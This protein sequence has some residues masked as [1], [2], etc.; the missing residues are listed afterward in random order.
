LGK[1]AAI[2]GFGTV[3]QG[4]YEGIRSHQEYIKNVL[5]TS[6]EIV[7]I[8]IKDPLKD[9]QIDAG[10]LVTNK[11]EDILAIPDLEIVF[12]AIVGK[13]PCFSYL[14]QI[15]E[16]GCHVITANK[17]MFAA[18][19]HELLKLAEKHHV[20]VKYEATV[21][22]G[23]PI[24]G[25][26]TNLLQ[27]N[28]IFEIQGILN[29]TSNY[30]LTEMR[31]GNNSF[32]QALKKA[33]ELGYAEADPSSDIEGFDAFYKLNILIHTVTGTN[34][35]WNRIERKGIS[36]IT[37]EQIVIADKL[38][39]RFRHMAYFSNYPNEKPQFW[40]KPVLIDVN[41]P[42]YSIDGVDNTIFVKGSL[43]SGLTFTGPGAGKFAT[44]SA[45]IEDLLQIYHTKDK[46]K[47]RKDVSLIQTLNSEKN[48]NSN[49]EK[50]WIIFSK[51]NANQWDIHIQYKKKFNIDNYAIFLISAREQV[52]KQ[53]F[54]NANIFVYELIGDERI[55]Q[56][57]INEQQLQ[58]V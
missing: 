5:G 46:I 16:K 4:I 40:V 22:G 53:Y 28:K 42:F 50:N 2:L 35:E 57:K 34:I 36:S 38:G 41:H 27:A 52:I 56:I 25:A 1:K 8:L 12:E 49:N 18:Y 7:A 45:M 32:D 55:D 20:K 33:Q 10:V 23:V 37:K 21:A 9:R 11:I 29:G 13:D 48:V 19:G 51:L 44:A 14:K 31:K 43:I 30:I 58:I 6:I 26:L 17:A 54:N 15:I 24:I 39:L 3:G 47:K